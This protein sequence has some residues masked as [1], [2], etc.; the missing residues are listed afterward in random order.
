[1]SV[2]VGDPPGDEFGVFVG[3]GDDAGVDCWV[4]LVVLGGGDE[5]LDC[6]PSPPPPS[7]LFAGEGLGVT[8]VLVVSFLLGCGGLIEGVGVGFGDGLISPF[9]SLGDLVGLGLGLMNASGL[10]STPD[11]FV[12]G[13]VG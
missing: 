8:K 9:L 4:V 7:S 13:C 11:D 3:A 12:S 1:M 6:P 10:K 2:G 5:P